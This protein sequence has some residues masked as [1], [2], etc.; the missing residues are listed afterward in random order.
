MFSVQCTTYRKVWKHN[1]HIKTVEKQMYKGKEK[2]ERHEKS[3]VERKINLDR[4][5]MHHVLG[6]FE[7][8]VLGKFEAKMYNLK[9]NLETT[10]TDLRS[11]ETMWY[12]FVANV[13]NNVKKQRIIW[14]EKRIQ[15]KGKLETQCT[16]QR[17]F[18]NTIHKVQGTKTTDLRNVETQC[19]TLK[20]NLG[21]TMYN[22]QENLEKRM[23]KLK[24]KFGHKTVHLQGRFGHKM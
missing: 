2:L 10:C 19:T 20:R 13:G 21:S 9:E 12:K 1:V 24:G 18:G 16:N 6:T 15:L 11:V 17:K 7:N 5:K 14:S 4:N 8:H 23:Y 22:W 3:K